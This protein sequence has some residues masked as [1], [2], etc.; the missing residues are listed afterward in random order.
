MTEAQRN[1]LADLAAKKGV[2]VKNTDNMSVSAASAKIEELE[3]LPDAEFR[4]IT[5]EE[6]EHIRSIVDKARKELQQW[7]FIQW[8]STS[9]R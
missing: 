5:E 8:V 7:S 1:Y 6:S 4:E 9:I 2:R 3:K